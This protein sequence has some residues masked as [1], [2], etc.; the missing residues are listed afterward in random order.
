MAAAPSEGMAT[1]PPPTI[2]SLPLLPLV[3]IARRLEYADVTK[4]CDTYPALAAHR[5]TLLQHARPSVIAWR[6]IITGG[7][8]PDWTNIYLSSDGAHLVYVSR[9]EHNADTDETPNDHI[10]VGR[11]DGE[12]RA[13]A[14][15]GRVHV[16][17]VGYTGDPDWRFIIWDPR[18]RVYVMTTDGSELVQETTTVAADAAWLP[19]RD[20]LARCFECDEHRN[21][22]FTREGRSTVLA[23]LPGAASPNLHCVA[24]SRDWRLCATTGSDR[25]LYVWDLHTGALL[26]T[27]YGPWDVQGGNNTIKFSE[28]GT[29]LVF[30]T[31]MGSVRVWDLVNGA[32]RAFIAGT[33]DDVVGVVVRG[34]TAL[35]ARSKGWYG[36]ATSDVLV[37]DLV[38][39]EHCVVVQRTGE[40]VVVT[41]LSPDCTRAVVVYSNDFTCTLHLGDLAARLQ[42][43]GKRRAAAAAAE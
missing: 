30:C 34:S 6:R 23:A 37:V 10:Y 24:V 7:P 41:A 14:V 28:D 22:I 21:F 43:R 29:R 39:G 2:I 8:A 33:V 1:P 16:S 11:V 4:L 19:K 9:Y 36:K 35:V 5:A 12:L 13:A 38:F 3:R 25:K 15:S 17:A 20:P 32:Q 42:R 27:I 26:H 31:Y 18:K 40:R